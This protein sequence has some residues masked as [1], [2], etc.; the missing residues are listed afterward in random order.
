[1]ERIHAFTLY[2]ERA[3]RW[4]EIRWTYQQDGVEPGTRE[5]Q[6]LV[7]QLGT[8]LVAVN[9]WL[10]RLGADSG[11]AFGTI[12]EYGKVLLYTLTWLA[13]QPVRLGTAQAVDR[14]LFALER[15]DMRA[16]FA[17]LD[18]PA[19]AVQARLS[20]CQAGQ[21]PVGYQELHLSAATRNVR[22]SALSTFYDWLI[23]EYLPEMKGREASA[24]HPLERVEH[25]LSSWQEMQRPEGLLP[26]SMSQV[27]RPSKLLRRR[28]DAP[29]PQALSLEEL[30]L[31][32]EAIPLVSHGYNAAT[33]NSALLR[34]MLWGMLRMAE[35]V[36]LTW[37]AVD[38]Q[39][40]Q[41]V[42]KGRKSRLVPIV[43]PSTWTYVNTYTSELRLPLQERF[44]GALFR[45]LDHE[46]T[47]L[48]KHSVE[49]LL[50]ALK[51]HFQQRVPTVSIGQQQ[52]LTS[53]GEKLHSHIFRAT[54]A[55]LLAAAGMDLLR[56]SLLLGHENP[57]TTQRY[58]LAAEQMKLS[59]EVRRI[60]VRVQE[61]LDRSSSP[62]PSGYSPLGWYERKGYLAAETR[63]G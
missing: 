46:E 55:T 18:L 21:L 23:A 11:Y 63:E 17:W 60:G 14:S 3:R 22:V 32:F 39:V 40:M 15:A 33:R 58:Y 54:G 13:Q 5:D 38:G 9:V 6:R 7:L 56:L 19:S 36:T 10:T 24:V 1:M 27:Q 41:I 8:S 20:V 28:Q 31:V 53:L 51:A 62:A 43:D 44:H 49:H 25:P 57:A 16:L 34:V 2:A 50:L 29:C 59:E 52:V 4:C 26:R 47:A 45:Q 30:R 42:G 35:L 12:Y 48:T 61:A 37:E